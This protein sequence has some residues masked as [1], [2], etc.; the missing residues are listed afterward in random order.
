MPFGMAIS[1]ELGSRTGSL[2]LIASVPRRHALDCSKCTGQGN[3][4][5][6]LLPAKPRVFVDYVTDAL[7]QQG[8][9][10]R[11]SASVC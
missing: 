6:R 8:I 3:A 9:A 11:Y 2:Q 5:K 4:S 10:K 7:R 1:A